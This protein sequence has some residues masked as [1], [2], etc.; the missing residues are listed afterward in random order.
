MHSAAASVRSRLTNGWRSAPHVGRGMSRLLVLLFGLPHHGPS[1]IPPSAPAASSAELLRPGPTYVHMG[2]NTRGGS[3]CSAPSDEGCALRIACTFDDQR[4]SRATCWR[5]ILAADRERVPHPCSGANE[6]MPDLL[7]LTA[8]S[9]MVLDADLG[10]PARVH[11]PVR[12][13]AP[14]TSSLLASGK[15]CERRP[16]LGPTP[17]GAVPTASNASCNRPTGGPPASM[18]T[19]GRPGP[20]FGSCELAYALVSPVSS[21]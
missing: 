6:M 3:I 9:S 16:S 8:V 20:W 10:R 15:G 7:S 4:A 2:F 14:E 12:V 1:G 21:D 17:S 11:A 18:Y 19:K 5:P 13:A